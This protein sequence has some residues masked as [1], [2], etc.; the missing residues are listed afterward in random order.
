MYSINDVSRIMNRGY[1]LTELD[2]VLYDKFGL[3]V[4]DVSKDGLIGYTYEFRSS[5][6]GE[7]Y[8]HSDGNM[9][10]ETTYINNE[11]NKD[12]EYDDVPEEYIPYFKQKIEEMFKIGYWEE[13]NE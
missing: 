13:S 8:I 11:D 9:Y 3:T 12:F 4:H 2:E 10:E 1:E 6:S 7:Y 5:Y